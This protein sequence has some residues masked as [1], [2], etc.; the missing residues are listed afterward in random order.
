M[1]GWFATSTLGPGFWVAILAVA[2]LLPVAIY[3]AMRLRV[4][5]S[6]FADVHLH[7]RGIAISAAVVLAMGVLFWERPLT[8]DVAWYL[9]ATRDWLGGAALYEVIMEINPPLNFYFTAPA[10][11][12]ADL[13]GLSDP[14][15]QYAVIWVVLFLCLIWCACIIRAEFGL[16]PLRQSLLLVAIATAII[17]PS[18]DSIGQREYLLV[19]L[20]MPWLLRQIPERVAAPRQEIAA[21]AIAALGVCLKPHFVL[22]PLA[23]T[24]ARSIKS[25]SLRPILS[26]AN[27]TFL[28]IGLAYVGFV[29]IAHPAYL[30]EIVPIARMVY[31]AYDADLPTVLGIALH[32]TIFLL[33]PVL[34]ALMNRKGRI[35]PT[36]FATLSLAGLLTYVLQTKGFDYHMIPFLSFGLMGCF[37]I[38]LNSKQLGPLA[39]AA[40]VAAAG[41]MGLSISQGFHRNYSVDQISRVGESLGGFKSLMVL[42]PHIFAG[43]PVALET[44]AKWI[45]RYPANWLVPG[46]LNRLARTDCTKEAATC[47]T[48]RAI[49]DRNRSENIADMIA[50]EP[51]LLIIDRDSEY[52]DE[53]RFDWLGFM[54]E[55][56]AWAGVFEDYQEFGSSK[57]YIYF[58]RNP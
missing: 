48:L 49:A 20:M 2:L 8:N 25:R 40:A 52:F 7:W 34:I 54:S 17:V 15:G 22:F 30:S 44:G 55:D 10:I 14:N 39:A 3:R 42:T 21:A 58:L 31:G 50:F 53:P 57:R 36:P 9:V 38:L 47:A 13:F 37:W 46:A 19:V 4:Y 28:V 43:P 23:L 5:P 27:L 29:A 33:L 1:T 56:P 18:L 51:E 45:S 12:V 35:E 6:A 24:V 16:S 32:E 41:V 26:T 11:V